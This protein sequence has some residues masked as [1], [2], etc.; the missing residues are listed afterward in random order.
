MVVN[1]PGDQMFVD[2]I[3]FLIDDDYEVLYTWCY[4][5]MFVMP[6]FQILE[7]QLVLV[8]HTFICKLYSYILLETHLNIVFLH[9]Y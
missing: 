7:S 2:F 8:K 9:F 6:C 1:F 5:I 4:G 3:T